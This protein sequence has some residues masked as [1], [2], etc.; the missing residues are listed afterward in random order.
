MKE[1]YTI[2]SCINNPDKDG[3]G[4]FEY[5]FRNVEEVDKFLKKKKEEFKLLGY[6]LILRE[7]GLRVSDL[8]VG[9]AYWLMARKYQNFSPELSYWLYKN[10]E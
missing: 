5:H 1:Q 6:T 9:K 4:A 3:S 10:R 2:V 7:K 8:V